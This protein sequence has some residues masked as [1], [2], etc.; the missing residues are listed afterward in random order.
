VTKKY[1]VHKSLMRALQ[2][3]DIPLKAFKDYM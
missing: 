1:K 2:S 3:H